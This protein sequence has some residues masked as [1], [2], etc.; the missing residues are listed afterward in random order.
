MAITT[1][2][3]PIPVRT[4]ISPKT[5]AAMDRIATVVMRV[6]EMAVTI[7]AGVMD[8]ETVEVAAEDTIAIPVV[9][10]VEVNASPFLYYFFTLQEESFGHRRWTWK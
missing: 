4:T 9:A 2:T 5:K 10:T 1:I 8:T 7:T 6:A 3:I